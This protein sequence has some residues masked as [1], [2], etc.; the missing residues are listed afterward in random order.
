M[1]LS[2]SSQS[3]APFEPEVADNLFAISQS[4]EL[5][6]L[7]SPDNYTR[8]NLL[9]FNSSI[10]SHLRHNIDHYRSLLKGLPLR[11]IDYDDRER[12]EAVATDLSVASGALKEL[13]SQ[14]QSISVPLDSAVEVKM[15]TGEQDG[16]WAA[17]SLRREL[18]FVLSHSV[19]HFALIAV[20]CN[21]DGISTPANFGVAPST[22]N[23]DQRSRLC[24]H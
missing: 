18:Q 14:L 4:C 17:S 7:L 10:G 8:R 5:I 6:A 15:E 11:R 13:A 16:S 3:S 2:F 23:F 22:L 1:E 9:C 12:D 21:Q 24:A 19:H 20:I